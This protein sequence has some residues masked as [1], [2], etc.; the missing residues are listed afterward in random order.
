MTKIAILGAGNIGRAIAEILKPKKAKIEF[1]DVDPSKVPGQKKLADIIPGADFIFLCVPSFAIP[2]ATQDIKP[3]LTRKTIVVSIAKGIE[4]KS[5][6]TIDALL[7]TILPPKQPFALLSGPMLASELIGHQG[8]SAIAAAKDAPARSALS[9]IFHGTELH[10]ETSSDVRGTA[11]A[12]VLKNVYAV[13]LGALEGM[14]LGW[15]AKGLLAAEALNEMS[16][17]IPLLGGKKHTAT[18][19]AGLG[20]LI[21][22]GMSPASRNHQTGYALATGA[23]E[24]STSEGTNA[25]SFVLKRLGR[26]REK[27]VLLMIAEKLISN[28]AHGKKA[29]RKFITGE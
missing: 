28:P 19:S 20:D 3:Y 2:Q 27:F 18:C 7:A 12:G 6:K 11:F 16:I 4:V 24:P 14:Q 15:N 1:W 25:L 23:A 17:L 21:A 13:L 26:K 9:N 10:V 22:T 29:L 5:G 8:G